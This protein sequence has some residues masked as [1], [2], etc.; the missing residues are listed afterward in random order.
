MTKPTVDNKEW[1]NQSAFETFY[2]EYQGKSASQI[3]FVRYLGNHPMTTSTGEVAT[4]NWLGIN[5]IH[6][7]HLW[8]YPEIKEMKRQNQWGIWSRFALWLRGIEVKPTADHADPDLAPATCSIQE[9]GSVYQYS[10]DSAHE[11]SGQETDIKAH[12][13]KYKTVTS[14]K[15]NPK[16]NAQNN[17]V[18][19]GV[20]RGAATSFAALATHSAEYNQVKMCILEGPPATISG[21]VKSW[22]WFFPALGKWIYKVFSWLFLGSDHKTDRDH[23]AVSYV[24]QFPDHVPLLVVSSKQDGVVPHK[25]SLNIAL[26]VAAKRIEAI[27]NATD[28]EAKKI[29]PVYILQLD[30][31][32]H[33]DYAFGK[34]RERYQNVVHAIYKK[35]QLPYIEEYA[36]KGEHELDVAELTQGILKSQVIIQHN[37]KMNKKERDNIRTQAEVDFKN[38]VFKPLL[39]TL[40]SDTQEIVRNAKTLNRAVSICSSMP[41]YNKNIDGSFFSGASKAQKQ[42]KRMETAMDEA[43]KLLG[44]G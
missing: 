15:F 41:L 5:T 9:E 34:E 29:A 26:K 13:E 33:Q 8:T 4:L 19:Y 24:D 12:F 10:I 42:L 1:I 43:S 11:S 36:E 20:S 28:E 14:I 17:I 21:S 40:H 23:Q 35:H 25:G 37:F 27:K 3:Q 2:L 6:H 7:T 22:F 18:L 16:H 30:S 39:P 31:S 38:N 44:A 32:G